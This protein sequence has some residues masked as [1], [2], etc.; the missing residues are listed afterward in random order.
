MGR[1]T[2]AS[3]GA[4]PADSRRSWPIFADLPVVW[5]VLDLGCGTGSVAFEL[6]RRFPER[7]IFAVDVSAAYLAFAQGRDG[8]RTSYFNI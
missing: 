5:P 1:P 6:R 8:G 4:G 2:S 3:S 7:S